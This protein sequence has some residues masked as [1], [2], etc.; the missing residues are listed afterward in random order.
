MSSGDIVFFGRYDTYLDVYTYKN[1]CVC[2]YLTYR[3][4]L[5][6]FLED[7]THIWMCTHTKICACV[8]I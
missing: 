8:H 5:S 7:M 3:E 4:I 1:M 2:T 6:F